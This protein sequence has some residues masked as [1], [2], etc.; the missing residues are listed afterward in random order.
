MEKYKEIINVAL[1]NVPFE[2]MDDARQASY[3]GLLNG[4]TNKKPV[5]NKKGYLYRCVV[6]EIIKEL[7]TLQRPF[8]LNRDVFC[9]LIKYRKLKRYGQEHLA[10]FNTLP[11]KTLEHIMTSEQKSLL[12][13]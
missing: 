1:K 2:F 4:L 10:K 11:I 3:I 9:K 12:Y 8:S 5:R 13:E 7:A 6:N